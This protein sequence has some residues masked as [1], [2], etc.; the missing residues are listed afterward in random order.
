M[1]A[2]GGTELEPRATRLVR[3]EAAGR[4]G[5]IA[6]SAPDGVLALT[7][8]FLHGWRA[9]P[10]ARDCE[11]AVRCTGV[12]DGFEIAAPVLPGTR[13]RAAS[14]FEAAD[15]VASALAALAIGRPEVILPHAAALES[16]AGLVLLFADTTGGKSTLAL[17]LAAAGWRLF[18][19]DRLGLQ[20]APT[21][22][23]GVALGLAPKLR[24][25]LPASARALSEFARKRV[26]QSWPSLA[27]LQLAPEEQAGPAAEAPV[28]ACLLL[29]RSG[30]APALEPAHPARLVR[31]LAE[32]AAAPWLAPAEV[33]A[34]AAAHA[35]LPASHLSYDE[36]ADAVPLLTERFGHSS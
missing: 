4:H 8:L 34:A 29:D 30:G 1:P 21:G 18:G 22:S 14:A 20:R 25:P 10:A 28:A 13:H 5:G 16:P 9:M 24:L 7:P 12:A 23:V 31:A 11:V 27:Y 19:D 36:A 32:S 26:R 2:A 17:T 15:V 6:V 3:F 33:M 35:G